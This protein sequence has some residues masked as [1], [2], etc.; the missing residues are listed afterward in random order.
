M[1]LHIVDLVLQIEDLDLSR[2]SSANMNYNSKNLRVT[3]TLKMMTSLRLFHGAPFK[4]QSGVGMH[5]SS[6]Y[7][8]DT[9]NN[10]AISDTN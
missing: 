6:F 10:L 2:E 4:K 7:S 5:H 3:W 1:N 9:D 8:Y